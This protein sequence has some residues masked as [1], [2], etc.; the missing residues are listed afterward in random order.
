MKHILFLLLFLP[1]LAYAQFPANPNKIRLGNQTTADGLVVRTAAAPSWTPSSINNAW[2]A[3]D[4]VA[5]VFYYYD[6][7]TWNIFSSGGGIDSTQANNGLAL[8]GDTVQLGGTLTKN[9]EVDINGKTMRFRDAAGY[10]DLF[11]NGTYGLFGSDANTYLDI[12]SVAGRAR[13]VASTTA[14]LTSAANTD[15]SATD[16]VTITGQRIR[17]NA[18]DTRIQQVSKSNTLNRVMMID[19]I[20]EQIY[21]RDVSSIAGGGGGSG[22]VTSITAGV[23]LTG[24]TITTSG[25]IAADTSGMLVSKSFLTNQG[26][27]TNVGTVTGTGT[28]NTL[29]KWTSSTALGNSLITDDGARVTSGGTAAFR[30]PNG[31]TAQRPGTPLAGDTRYSTTNGTLEYYGA[32]A[33]EVPVRGA[34]ATGLG[35]PY[36]M[37]IHDAN[38]RVASA[39]DYYYLSGLFG[40]GAYSNGRFAIDP[41]AGQTRIARIGQLEIVTDGSAAWTGQGFSIAGANR[42]FVHITSKSNSVDAY[43]WQVGSASANASTYN[44]ASGTMN[45][46]QFIGGQNGPSGSTAAYS[47]LRILSYVNGESTSPFR[48][49]YIQK[50]G[51]STGTQE[52][53]AIDAPEGIVA[54]GGSVAVGSSTT[55]AQTFHVTGTARITG[56]D[57]TGTHI[58]LRDAD[59]DI[60][61]ATLG[62]GLSLTSG[63]LAATGVADNLYTANGTLTGAR[64][65][66]LGSNALTFSGTSGAPSGVN[67]GMTP[68]TNT[69]ALQSTDG[70]LNNAT[71]TVTPARTQMVT[72]NTTGGTAATL[73]VFADS[74]KISPTPISLNDALS[75]LVGINTTTGRLHRVTKSTIAGMADPGSNG[76]LA[77]TAANTTT[78][79]TITAGSGIA[80][81]NGDGVSGNPT[82]SRTYSLTHITI[83]GG[84]TFF[85]TTPER[86][87]NDTPGTQTS[88]AIGSDFGVSGS[89]LDYTGPGGALLRVE[90]SVSFSVADDGDYY[91]SIF[92]EGTEIAATSTRISCV[93]GNYYTVALPATTTTGATNDT[94]DVRIAATTGT[95]T[96]TMHRYGF[97][98]ER[99]Y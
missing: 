41:I 55:P 96:T 35:T 88:T 12:G 94:F 39:P 57:G 73:E 38:G 82:I 60:S 1:V 24:G 85:G 71:I 53:R 18:V 92:K 44:R 62:S 70:S 90:G 4:T 28:T 52:Y 6:A 50:D 25:T 11:M 30:L 67:F 98:I 65:V 89:T 91:L 68:S 26:Y 87:D 48:A 64:T 66:T 37:P 59:G 78:A 19:S 9:T 79:R 47:N 2:L 81:T 56:S 13:I 77:R 23:G 34:S 42:A 51:S 3:F 49:L 84:S 40:T 36:Y 95:S 63:T 61:N 7:G 45:L 76:I 22:T 54:I 5:A 31:T 27:T 43:T 93:A 10:P 83:S 46:H 33:W 80:V 21:Y 14:Q 72:I 15:V 97:I 86:P 16:T 17:L 29:A 20:T 74:V 8:S 69:I 58:M 32:S 99:V 75:F